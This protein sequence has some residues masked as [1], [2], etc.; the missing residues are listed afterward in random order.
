[1]DRARTLIDA[2]LAVELQATTRKEI[3]SY[4]DQVEEGTLADADRE[5]IEA[6]HAR[7]VGNVSPEPQATSSNTWREPPPVAVWRPEPGPLSASSAKRVVREWLANR[8]PKPSQPY[9]YSQMRSLMEALGDRCAAGGLKQGVDE[10]GLCEMLG[11]AWEMLQ[12]AWYVAAPDYAQRYRRPDEG[13]LTPEQEQKLEAAK[14][15]LW[16]RHNVLEVPSRKGGIASTTS[17][18]T[19]RL[20]LMRLPHI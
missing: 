13:P 8:V 16:K 9:R 19:R 17:Q 18:S 7:L 6:L 15:R 12:G 14:N 11:D 10:D 5:Y 1:M 3:I 20:S 4:R 2:L